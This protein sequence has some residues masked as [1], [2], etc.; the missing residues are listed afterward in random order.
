MRLSHI[1]RESPKDLAASPCGAASLR[2]LRP[3]S[4]AR[5]VALSTILL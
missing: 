4:A 3:V 2:L 1:R 5:A